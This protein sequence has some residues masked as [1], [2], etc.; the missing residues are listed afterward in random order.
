MLEYQEDFTD[1]PAKAS[2]DTPGNARTRSRSVA[3]WRPLALLLL[4]ISLLVSAPWKASQSES[5]H[6]DSPPPADSDA[7]ASA[8]EIAEQTALRPASLADD[9]DS[10]AATT[11][12][13]VMPAH[14]RIPTA[15]VDY[16]SLIPSNAEV[17]ATSALNPADM[18]GTGMAIAG[19][20]ASG[21]TYAGIRS[22][23]ASA[24]WTG[25]PSPSH[26]AAGI[27]TSFPATLLA[28]SSAAAGT[29]PSDGSAENGAR[30]SSAP[31]GLAAAQSPEPNAAAPGPTSAPTASAMPF[32]LPED[33]V[34]D[35]LLPLRHASTGDPDSSG[36]SLFEP[37]DLSAAVDEPF[38]TAAAI[39]APG[40]GLLLLWAGA[41]LLVFRGRLGS[42]RS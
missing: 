39:P 19:F 12:A 9:A 1:L 14:A 24:A 31:S 37:G 6:A 13:L 15:G 35:E 30:G 23:I 28:S 3:R 25:F 4:L 10:S 32:A 34:L 16:G 42:P 18:L 41:L 17:L 11:A 29:T 40:T 22:G 27:G 33:W 20:H 7:T 8:V 21:P 26:I 38:V 5:M 2:A 36:P